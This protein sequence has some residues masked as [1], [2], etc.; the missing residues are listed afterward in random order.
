VDPRD[1]AEDPLAFT[2]QPPP[3]W[4]S[5]PRG[6][7][8]PWRRGGLRK[9]IG[10]E[11]VKKPAPRLCAQDPGGGRPRAPSS[12]LCKPAFPFQAFPR[13]RGPRLCGWGGNRRASPRGG[14][15]W[16]CGCGR[17]PGAPPGGIFSQGHRLR[18][19]GVGRSPEADRPGRRTLS[20]SGGVGEGHRPP[21]FSPSEDS[22]G[23]GQRL[24][25]KV[26]PLASR[27]RGCTR[28]SLQHRPASP[29]RHERRCGTFRLEFLTGAGGSI[30]EGGLGW[31]RGWPHPLGGSFEEEK[32]VNSLKSHRETVF[33]WPLITP[34]YLVLIALLQRENLQR[35]RRVR[36]IPP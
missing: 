28:A 4:Q 18:W 26:H 19:R 9:G 20:P 27:A 10:S 14:T 5:R 3:R 11:R 13:K 36:K 31:G 35:N 22:P 2:C 6:Q 12:P 25:E 15:R 32:L 30:E 23:D 21:S 8:L 34:L 1:P 29:Y 33:V 24:Q 7:K 17:D 16:V